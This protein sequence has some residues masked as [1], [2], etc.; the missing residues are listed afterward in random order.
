MQVEHAPVQRA[1]RGSEVAVKVRE[2]A[3][4]NDQIFLIRE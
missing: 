3:R 2:R 1:E 4:R